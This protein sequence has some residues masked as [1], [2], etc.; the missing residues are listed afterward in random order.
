M[1]LNRAL[2]GSRS[3]HE[4]Q[5]SRSVAFSAR[6]LAGRRLAWIAGVAGGLLVL[7][8]AGLIVDYR[9]RGDDLSSHRLRE[10]SSITAADLAA[11][12]QPL[13][14]GAMTLGI[15]YGA[16]RKD[17]LRQLGPP[18]AR[19]GRCWV[20]RGQVG[21]IRG[22]SSG[23]FVNAMKFC[24]S[25]GPAGGEAVMHIFGYR[26]AHTVTMWDPETGVLVKKR[27]PARWGPTIAIA[28]VPDSYVQ[29]NS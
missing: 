7:V 27:F 6:L 9:P 19:Q 25:E 26:P 11:P 23:P 1:R 10:R 29:G 4:M 5:R 13:H 3:I 17:V 20:Y 15:A 22:R 16:S 8:S 2:E 21:R 18:T 12:R 14:Y 24:F 28:R